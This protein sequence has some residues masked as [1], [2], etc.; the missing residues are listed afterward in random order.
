LLR[1]E[2]TEAD[3]G[4]RLDSFIRKKAPLYSRTQWQ[5]LIELGEVFVND[6]VCASSYRVSSGDVVTHEVGEAPPVVPPE[7]VPIDLIYQDEAVLVLNKPAGLIVHPT[8]EGRTGTLVNR[9]A[10]MGV[11]LSTLG[12][13]LRPGV[14]HRLDGT[15][16][17][18]MVAAKTDDAHERL[19]QQF[20]ERTIGK[21]YLAVCAGEPDLDGDVIDG[22]IAR[23]PRLR[24]RMAVSPEGGRPA[25]TTFEVLERYR[26][27]ALVAAHPHTGRTHQIRVHL[28][29]VGHPILGDTKYGGPMPRFSDVGEID[30]VD[31]RRRLIKRTALHAQELAFDHPVRGERMFFRAPW[32]GDFKRLV[33][34]LRRIAGG[35]G[36]GGQGRAGKNIKC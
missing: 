30:G 5:R 16:S 7:D 4:E 8:V 11:P 1:L 24:Q 22:A 36:A 29:L 10:A 34:A 32:P 26:G 17:G 25:K 13:R 31:P 33:E 28:A 15:T 35:L 18:V 9:L 23:H 19:K 14:V 20:K 21:V 3:A 2:A 27:F 6:A 12:G